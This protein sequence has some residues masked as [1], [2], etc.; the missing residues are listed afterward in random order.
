MLHRSND[1]SRSAHHRGPARN[2][3]GETPLLVLASERETVDAMKAL[4]EAGADADANARG[5]EGQTATVLA[6]QRGE[7]EKV[8]L[9][10]QHST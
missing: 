6:A 10:A 8:A 4:L 2:G 5:L 1:E 7:A 3:R 9:L